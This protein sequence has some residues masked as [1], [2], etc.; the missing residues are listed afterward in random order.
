T[1]KKQFCAIGSVKGSIGHTD[2]AAGVA[3]IIATALALKHKIL[4]PSVNY[5]APNP[6]IDFANSPFYV[7]TELR[8]WK[9]DRQPRRAGVS[10]FG[11][12]GTNAH[13]VLEETPEVEPSG[14]SRR[15]QQLVLSARTETALEKATDNLVAHLQANPELNPADV[16]YTLHVGRQAFDYRRA[17]V[18]E[19]AADAITTLQERDPKRV[20]TG[21]QVQTERPVVFMFSGQGAQYVNVGR[22]LYQHEAL[23]R[24]HVDT[25]AELLKPHLK[26]DLRDVLY[27]AEADAKEA[28]EKL[29]QTW[30]TQPALFV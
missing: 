15:Y 12:G 4:P 26:L 25:C 18:C 19:A 16:A 8:E 20:L 28:T 24:E 21:T 6:R 23:F 9:T 2:T 30:L 14:E 17:V 27:P 1:D 11:I 5:E 7:N 22:D 29:E 13:A 3:N 10:A